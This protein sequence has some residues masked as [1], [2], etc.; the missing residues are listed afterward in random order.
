MGTAMIVGKF[1]GV[2][3][4]QDGEENLVFPFCFKYLKQTSISATV[5]ILAMK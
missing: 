4:F 1:A 3:I 5:G 2:A